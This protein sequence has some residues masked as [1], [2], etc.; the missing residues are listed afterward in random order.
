MEEKPGGTEYIDGSDAKNYNYST[1]L[2]P[3]AHHDAACLGNGMT[4]FGAGVRACLSLTTSD[5]Q[6][7][8]RVSCFV[9]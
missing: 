5:L 8:L 2:L 1:A 6:C 7:S 4:V 9:C 3:H